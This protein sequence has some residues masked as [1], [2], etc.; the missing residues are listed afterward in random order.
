MEDT[1]NELLKELED[2]QVQYSSLL[3][4]QANVDSMSRELHSVPFNSGD[5]GFMMS[6]S[7]LV[8]LM[9]L[10]G[11]SLFYSGAVNIKHIMATFIQTMS[12]SAVI[13]VLWMLCGYSLAF[14][15]S[16]SSSQE[17]G[18]RIYGDFNQGWLVDLDLNSVHQLAPTIPET[19]FCMFQLTNAI[20]ACALIIGGFACRTKF[21][22]VLICI[23]L[24]LLLVYCPLSHMHRHPRGWLFKME[25]L[26]FAGG[27][28]VH[29]SA[30][31]TAL[32]ASYYIG[33]RSNIQEQERFESRNILLS[34]WGAC[35]VLVGWF[36]F[37]MGSSYSSDATSSK[38]LIVTM[39]GASA[40]AISWISV[41]W[42]RTGTPSILG[43]LCGAIAGLVSI[44][45]GVGYFDS[46]GAVV[47]GICAG[48]CCYMA[49]EKEKKTRTVDDPLSTFSL[50]FIGGLVGG[51]LVG[52]FA[53]E[54]AS[55]LPS[56]SV[57]AFYGNP[58]QVRASDNF[59]YHNDTDLPA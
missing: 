32:M 27:N 23:S 11:I 39:L 28:V 24:W 54:G 51:F 52:F 50:N 6:C 26:D 9:T 3:Q 55:D 8:M 56:H 45:A 35:F 18:T 22:S 20:I 29:I 47:T 14:S 2:L 10:P 37:N 53:K 25:V 57:G 46:T 48:F 12:V 59:M 1:V 19:A 13:T 43:I 16:T 44:S 58:R 5:T 15:P 17:E 7:A 42:Y 40:S 31:I 38:T 21:L 33:P 49:V 30:G 41:E 34:V 4:S 36:G